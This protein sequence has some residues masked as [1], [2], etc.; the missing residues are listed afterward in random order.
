MRKKKK[1]VY[2]HSILLK[3]TLTYIFANQKMQHE[4]A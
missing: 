3:D 4:K 2:L 1:K